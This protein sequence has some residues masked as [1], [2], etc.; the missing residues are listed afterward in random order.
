MSKTFTITSYLQR[1]N[2]R[3]FPLKVRKDKR[4]IFSYNKNHWSNEKDSATK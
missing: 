2:G 4:F 3:H 1:K